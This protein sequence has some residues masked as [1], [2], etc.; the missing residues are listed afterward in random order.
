[1]QAATTMEIKNMTMFWNRLNFDD[2]NRTS[3]SMKIAQQIT[4]KSVAT[5]GVNGLSFVVMITNFVV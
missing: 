4:V 1:M 5:I 3:R 2:Q